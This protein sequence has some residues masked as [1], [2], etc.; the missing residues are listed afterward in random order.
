MAETTGLTRLLPGDAGSISLGTQ[1]VLVVGGSAIESLEDIDI[2]E[3][4]VVQFLDCTPP[5]ALLGR[6]AELGIKAIGISPIM[7]PRVVNRVVG[8]G[9]PLRV[10]ANASWGVI[11][12]GVIGCELVRKLSSTGASA[13]IADVRT[14]RSGILIELNVRRF[15]LDLL[16]AGSDA[17]SLHLYPG[18]TAS[19]LI[20]ER[21][22]RLMKP[23]AVLINVS[24]SSVVDEEAVIS[25]LSDGTLAGYATDCPGDVIA[26]ADDALAKSGKL[27]VTTNPL[28]NQ[29]GAA[30]QIAKYVAANVQAFADGSGVDGI[31]DVVD[32]PVL[33]DPSFWSSRMSPRQ[34]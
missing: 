26:G 19:P 28:T 2:S 12:L 6:L 21:E 20:S 5:A 13:I 14:P 24:D 25:A 8:F 4:G 10:K 11:G 17:I 15:S 18:P 23:E 22:L 34:D 16:I 9:G 32:F 29:I 7:A 3:S 33:G 27:I 30:Q 31:I 1:D